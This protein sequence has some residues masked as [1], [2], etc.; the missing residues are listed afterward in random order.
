MQLPDGR[1]V[2]AHCANPGAMTSCATPGWSVRLSHHPDP[3]RKLKWT[4]QQVINDQGVRI[5]VNTALPNKV[6][7]EALRA[8]AVPALSAYDGV[9]AEVRYGEEKSRVDFLLSAPGEP[10]CYLEVKAVSL[11]LDDGVGAFPDSVSKRATRHL[12]ELMREL[13]QGHRSALLFAVTRSDIH[14][15]RPADHIDPTYGAAL[16]EA[17]QAGV[18][19]LAHRLEVTEQGVTL[20]EALPVLLPG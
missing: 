7:G 6:V 15:V 12:R 16:R 10:D 3:K 9:R 18:Q 14:Q 20:G 19:L 5:L 1:E 2:V 11:R 17:A 4:L 13:E 8:Q